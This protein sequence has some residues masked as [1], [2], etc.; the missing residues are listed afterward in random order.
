MSKTTFSRTLD[1]L[2]QTYP[3]TTRSSR[4]KYRAFKKVPAEKREQVKQMVRQEQERKA[5][6][7]A[8]G[9]P[10]TPSAGQP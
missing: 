6:Q 5:Q 10:A 4:E 2:E 1:G 8:S 3:G 7:A 9:V